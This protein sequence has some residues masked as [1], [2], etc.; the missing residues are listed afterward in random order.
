MPGPR[1]AAIVGV[2]TTHQTRDSGGRTGLSYGLEALRGALD[3]AG[4]E[5]KDIQGLFAQLSGW[6]NAPSEGS[7]Y[8]AMANWPYQLGIPINW[9]TGAVNAA[10]TGAAAILD[11]TAAIRM[12]S[13]DTVAIVLGAARPAQPTGK[14][15]PWTWNAHEFTQWTG[16]IT[17]AQFA[18]VA[19][20]HMHEYG[21][22]PEQLAAISVTIRNHASINPAAVMF[23]RGPYTVDDVLTS[24][25]IAEPLTV[26]MCA[27]VNDGGGALIMTTAERARSLRKPP[28]YVLGGADQLSYPAYAEAPLLKRHVGGDFSREWVARGFAQAGVSHDDIDVVE[29]YDGFAIWALMQLEMFGFCGEGEG[30]PLAQGNDLELDGRFPV[31]TDGGCQAF[32]HN[33]TPSLF[34][35]IE[36]VRQ[37]RGE[38]V[39]LCPG[40]ATGDHT[41]DRSICRKVRDPK[42]A[43][44]AG[45]GPPTGGG[46][47]CILAR[48]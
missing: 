4:L 15:A 39:D 6:P 40:W 10:G 37:L 5:L 33:G 27:L 42:I 9:L 38:V 20:R 30:G 35:P 3:D 14:T 13:V 36:A 26:L 21:T 28:V 17:P 47:F 2:H 19:R 41:Y 48:D 29:L 25:M 1:D 31:C 12:G 23:Q 34:R 45:M 44:A 32:S 11:A 46:N 24:R 22:T 43:F 7:G 16:S 8:Y 18:L